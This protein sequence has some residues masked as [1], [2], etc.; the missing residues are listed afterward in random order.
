MTNVREEMS[1]ETG[2]QQWNKGPRLKAATTSEEEEDIRQNL[3]EDR[4]VLGREANSRNF[5]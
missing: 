5:Y 2:R 4:K 1:G 3:Q